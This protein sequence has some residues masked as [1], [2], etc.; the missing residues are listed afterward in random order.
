MSRPRLSARVRTN[1]D[2]Q[3]M[4]RF[5]DGL[6]LAHEIVKPNAK[7]HPALAITL[8]CGTLLIHHIACTPR[9]R[10]NVDARVAGL[11][12]ALVKAGIAL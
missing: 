2:Y 10:C 9:G 3:A 5:I 4:S 12:R 1:A 8:P 7:G 6:G 11:K